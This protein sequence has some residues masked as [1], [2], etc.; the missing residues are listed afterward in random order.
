[1]EIK[2]FEFH[3]NLLSKFVQ[4]YTILIQN[5]FYLSNSHYYLIIL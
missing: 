5:Y 3:F 2:E 1:M 4:N